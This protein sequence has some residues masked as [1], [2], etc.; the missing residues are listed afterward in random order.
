MDASREALVTVRHD[1]QM[2]QSLWT[3]TVTGG[4]AA[5]AQSASGFLT[6]ALAAANEAQAHRL[7]LATQPFRPQDLVWMEFEVALAAVVAA[8][9]TVAFGL[10][11]TNNDDFAAINGGVW[12]RK[13]AAGLVLIDARDSVGTNAVAGA[14]TGQDLGTTFRRFRLNF[15]EGVRL[16]DPRFGGSVGGRSMIQASIE[17]LRG[18]YN[19]LQPVAR[20]AQLDLGA[21]VESLAPFVQIVKTGGVAVTAMYLRNFKLAYRNV[22]FAAV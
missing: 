1:S 16:G 22:P 14:V 9:V 4:P 3:R 7:H 12:F 18:T 20:G 21:Q 2:I 5:L 8:E 15:R 10:A 11:Q 13:T 19:Q 6:I 17:T